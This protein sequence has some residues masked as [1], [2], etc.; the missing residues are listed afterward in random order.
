MTLNVL[1][2]ITL[3]QAIFSL[4]AIVRI[5]GAS[6]GPSACVPNSRNNYDDRTQQTVIMSSE[7]SAVYI[8]CHVVLHHSL[9][10]VAQFLFQH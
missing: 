4:S 1:N 7:R 10:R 9:S 8:C 3:L 2:V 5:C 6:R